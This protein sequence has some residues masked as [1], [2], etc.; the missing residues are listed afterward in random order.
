MSYKIDVMPLSKYIFLGC[1]GE[2]VQCR[3]VQ[4]YATVYWG[5]K[6]SWTTIS[7]WVASL[8]V[9]SHS[10]WHKHIIHLCICLFTQT[11]FSSSPLQ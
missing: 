10:Y 7:F 5:E 3:D 2:V 6:N 11:H 9:A 8:G 1:S 4:V